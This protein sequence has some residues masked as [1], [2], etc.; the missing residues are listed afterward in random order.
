MEDFAKIRELRKELRNGKTS[1][2]DIIIEN[3]SEGDKLA[4]KIEENVSNLLE[5]KLTE[6]TSSGTVVVFVSVFFCISVVICA[7]ILSRRDK[8]TDQ[9]IKQS[10][11]LNGEGKQ[12]LK[13]INSMKNQFENTNIKIDSVKTEIDLVKN[14]TAKMDGKIELIMEHI[15]NKK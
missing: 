8:Q 3:Y 9:I 12:A 1:S 14:E 11:L 5:N 15:I 6:T 10:P 4:T 7:F 2:G 13:E